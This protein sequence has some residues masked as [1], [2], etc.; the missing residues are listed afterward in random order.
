MA[1]TSKENLES[2]S[3]PKEHIVC[4]YPRDPSIVHKCTVHLRGLVW[5]FENMV[6]PGYINYIGKFSNQQSVLFF[7]RL[8]HG[9]SVILTKLIILIMMMKLP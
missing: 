6:T 7:L 9:H 1:I 3:A 5:G 2:A 4:L 8:E